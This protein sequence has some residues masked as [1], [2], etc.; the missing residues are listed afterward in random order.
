[1]GLFWKWGRKLCI[2]A[3]WK[4]K[5]KSTLTKSKITFKCNLLL[6]SDKN[7]K[8]FPDSSVGKKICLQ[9]RR[10]QFVSWVKKILWRRDK[11]PTP[12]FLGFLGGSAGEQSA[13]NARDLGP[14]PGVGRSPGEGYPL[15][16]S[17]LE[18][19]IGSI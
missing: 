15:Q 18:N 19:S 3:L 11:L 2:K 12:V 8:G 16:Y 14:I 7:Q 10:S 1:M 6:L 9:C 17:G 4:F 5:K 13:Y